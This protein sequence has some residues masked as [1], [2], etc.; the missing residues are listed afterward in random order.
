MTTRL[1]CLLLLTACSGKEEE[2]DL[3]AEED[4]D[5]DDPGPH[6]LVPD[7]Y[8]GLWFTDPSLVCDPG[9]I[10]VYWL[11]DGGA[12]AAG[13]FTM[14]EQ[15]FWFYGAEGFAGDCVDTFEITG[16]YFADD[17]K[18]WYCSECNIGY[19][20][21]RRLAESNCSVSY[22]SFFDLEDKPEEEVYDHVALFQTHSSWGETY[23]GN[24]MSMVHASHVGGNQYAL[25]ST[26]W[27]SG[28]FDPQ[29]DDDTTFPAGY[30]WLGDS[31]VK[32]G[33]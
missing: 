3:P 10:K 1:C 31:C 30:D 27:A 20:F 12:D 29:G 13:D 21:E 14:T 11:A 26:N 22:Y 25:N 24:A 28:H 32:R 9:E 23:D 7:E 16:H 4:T 15:W 17:Y 19:M 18:E 2:T 6:P 8:Q 5:A 33:K